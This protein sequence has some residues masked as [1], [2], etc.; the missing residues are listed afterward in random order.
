MLFCL[1][2]TSHAQD[3]DYSGTSVANFLKVG[4][5]ARATS[6]GEAY[7]TQ[8]S[9]ATSL[10]WNPGAA[11]RIGRGSVAFSIIPWLVDSQISFI[12]VVL[13]LR[14]GTFG[15]DFVY[16]T[17]GEME[18]AT[19][20][21]QDGTGRFF[22]ANDLQLGLT[23][24]RNMTDRFSVGMKIKYLRE[25]LASVDA[26]AFAF[27]IGSLFYTP[28]FN[29]MKLA[30]TLS[31]FGT[32]MRFDGRDLSV[33]YAVPGSP[34]NKEVPA[35]LKTSEWELPLFFRIGAS[36]HLIKNQAVSLITS[37]EIIDSRDY[38]TRYSFGAELGIGNQFFIRGGYKFNYDEATYS[39]GTGIDLVVMGSTDIKV[40]YSFIDF[41]RFQA[42]QQVSLIVNL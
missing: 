3:V 8:S 23:Y 11:S 41:G 37:V 17:S 2:Y 15:L 32:K 14:I 36:T 21:E 5:G 31:N 16:F 20:E 18:I 4:V 34:S 39:L 12:G 38:D 25:E 27:D 26:N 22:D 10:Y 9:D 30:L 13:P 6:M 40:D 19:L 28:F 35:A 33:I 42:I 7:I 29:G 24:S 1:V